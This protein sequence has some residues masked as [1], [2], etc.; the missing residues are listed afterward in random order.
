MEGARVKE[1]KIV[2]IRNG[3][4]VDHVESGKALDILKA[5]GYPVKGSSKVVSE[6][7]QN[8]TEPVANVLRA[9]VAHGGKLIDTWPRNAANDDWREYDGCASN[10]APISIW[11]R[12]VCET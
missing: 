10:S 8:G 1:F 5:L 7:A 6:I 11:P 4:V 12:S 9:L 3:T 2:P